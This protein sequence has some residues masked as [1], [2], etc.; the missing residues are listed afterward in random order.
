VKTAQLDFTGQVITP[1]LDFLPVVQTSPM[2]ATTTQVRILAVETQDFLGDVFLCYDPVTAANRQGTGAPGD[3]L[4]A[5]MYTSASTILDWIAAHPGSQDACGL[6]VRYSPFDNYPDYIQSTVN[7][8]RLNIEQGAGYGRVS[9]VT[10]FAPGS[11]Q[12][13]NP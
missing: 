3:I 6:I 7:G 2:G 11:G 9:D 13:A 10:I 5:H 12:P 1:V 8:V 4:A